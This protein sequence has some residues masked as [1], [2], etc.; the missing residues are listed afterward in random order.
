MRS[1]TLWRRALAGAALVLALSG[2]GGGGGGNPTPGTRAKWT[3]MVFINGA[4]NL[5]PFG[6]LNVNQMEKIGSTTDVKIVVQWKQASCSG[7]GSPDWT[8]TRR[9]F[10]TQDGDTS[11]VNSQ[12]VQDLG[13]NVDMGDWRTLQEFITWTQQQYPADHYA[14]VI[15]NHGA[16]WRPTRGARDRRITAFPRS[17]SIDDHTR[18]EIQIWQ[19]PQALNVT[20]KMDAVIFD[21]SLM[22]MTE[23]A[24]EIRDLAQVMV[25]SEESPP[26]EGYVYD[27]FL[28]DLTGNPNMTAAQLG[29]Q[30]VNR[31]LESY[32]RDNNL[33]QSALN[34]S[35]MQAV[36]NSLNAFANSLSAHLSDSRDAILN[37]R[38]TA[39]SY[40]YPENKDLWDY[41]ELI[42]NGTAAQDLK[43]AAGNIQQ[44]I[45]AALIVEQHGNINARS[46]GLAIFVPTPSNYLSSY[47]NLAL[48]R[49]T[50]WDE[51]LQ[52]QPP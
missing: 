33:T 2:C 48:T 43:T 15:W 52:N 50:N 19:L 7:C 8:G 1:D 9:Y 3:F 16:G 42:K 20:P 46:H 24:Y 44:S 47:S 5:Q 38:N 12:L 26:G 27:T 51:W 25:G 35:A 22:Q 34:L 45:T 23:V 40:T 18:N 41:A 4:N 11:R 21:A 13:Q 37:A 6:P 31:T 14:L 36:A 29:T 32:G 10:I 17:V 39:Q 28:R 49:V 30:V